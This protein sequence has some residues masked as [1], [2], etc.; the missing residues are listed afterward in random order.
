MI[1][2][3]TITMN[4]MQKTNLQINNLKKKKMYF[5][6]TVVNFDESTIYNYK[7]PN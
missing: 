4:N 2:V 6:S 7:I 5:V 3:I 1:Q